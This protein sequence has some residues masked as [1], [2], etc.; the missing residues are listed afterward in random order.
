MTFEPTDRP[1]AVRR[2][3]ARAR[4]VVEL[5][6]AEM[7]HAPIQSALS[8]LAVALAVLAVTLLTG[9]G[10]GVLDTGQQKFANAD[11]D[12]WIAGDGVEV[13]SGGLENPIVDSHGVTATAKQHDAVRTA[14]PLAFHV[15]YLETDGETE[16][17]TGVGLPNTHGNVNIDEGK[18]FSEGDVHYANGSYDGP[19]TDEVIIDRSTADALDLKVG[20]TVRVAASRDRD[21]RE[22]TVVG[23][24]STY[25]KY[26]GSSTAVLPL[27]ELQHLTGTSGS[28]RATFVAVTIADGADRGAVRRDLDEEFPQYQVRTNREQLE[29]MLGSRALLLASAS[30]IVILAV[31]VGSAIML[32]IL[33]LSVSQQ[34]KELTA[35]HV[36]GLSRPML[37]GIVLTRCIVLGAVGAAVGLLLTPIFGTALDI[38]AARLVG[39]SNIIHLAPAVYLLGGGVAASISLFGS[40]AV[41]WY[42]TTTLEFSALTR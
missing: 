36:L 27:S 7:R 16:P 29:T 17:V 19:R 20:E 6:F 34:T 3:L 32:N 38:G 31:L 33:A 11:R 42:T 30:A 28:D 8:I 1:G 22:M 26:L 35:L 24:S 13:T 4:G 12:L 37:I 40:L 10:V 41:G 5:A 25:S 14:A 2:I 9:T 39:F 15:A 18:G 21:G 23:I